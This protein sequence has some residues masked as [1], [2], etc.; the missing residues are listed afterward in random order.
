MTPSLLCSS[1]RDSSSPRSCSTS[2][3]TVY[4]ANKKASWYRFQELDGEHGYSASHPLRNPAITDN[5][6]RRRLIIDPG[7]QSVSLR[8]EKQRTAKFAAGANPQSPQ[9]FPPPLSP[10]SIDYLGELIATQQDGHN[11]L[12]VLGGRGNSGSVRT[13]LGEPSI[14]NYANND[15]WFDDISDGPVTASLLCQI[16][17]GRWPRP[18]SPLRPG[19]PA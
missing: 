15:G 18:C 3:W 17:Q 8:T 14:Q 12:L 11:R 16:R 19:K 7:P 5:E 1:G 9:S 2:N 13:G 4:L 10:Y 6:T